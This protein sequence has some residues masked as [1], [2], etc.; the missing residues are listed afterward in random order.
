[1][2]QG[3]RQAAATSNILWNR[4]AT[5]LLWGLLAL[6]IFAYA[7]T[8]IGATSAGRVYATS[9]VIDLAAALVWMK[10]AEAAKPD[11]WIPVGDCICL[12]GSAVIIL[13][14]C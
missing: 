2:T 12:L 5:H 8:C 3:T 9:G 13:P 6:L 1:M 10:A 4:R 14:T 7:L 11:R